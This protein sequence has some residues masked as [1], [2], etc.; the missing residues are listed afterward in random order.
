M[1]QAVEQ[2]A[3]EVRAGSFPTTKESFRMDRSVLADLEQTKA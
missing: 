3:A 1:R 2:Y